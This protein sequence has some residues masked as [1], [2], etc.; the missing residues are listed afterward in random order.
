MRLVHQQTGDLGNIVE[1]I[2]VGMED[3]DL[4]LRAQARRD[5][6]YAVAAVDGGR[7]QA[8][9]LALL[10]IVVR[11]LQQGRRLARV[12]RGIPEIKFCHC[13]LPCLSNFNT[14]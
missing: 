13:R 11:D 8:H 3:V 7:V 10:F 2:R 4:A 9:L 14:I 5:T 1:E 6:S 12:H